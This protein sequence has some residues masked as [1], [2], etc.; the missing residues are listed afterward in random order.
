MLEQLPDSVE[1]L[2]GAFLKD[3][4]E[5]LTAPKKHPNGL[6]RCLAIS[7][8]SELVLVELSLHVLSAVHN[9]IEEKSLPVIH[10]P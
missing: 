8:K 2:V 6:Y 5:I 7:R 1:C 9:Q 10:K 3:G 4:S